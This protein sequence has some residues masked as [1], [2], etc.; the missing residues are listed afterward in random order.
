MRNKIDK[1][2]V[3]IL[4][5][6]RYDTAVAQLGF[7][8]HLVEHQRA[9]LLRVKSEMPSNSRPLYEVLMTGVPTY[10]NGIYSN[11]HAQRSK[12]LSIFELVKKAG[13][14][15]GAAAYYW[16]SE[17]YNQAPYNPLTDRIQHQ[18]QRLIQHGIFYSDDTYPD[19]HLFADA[20]HMVDQYQPD[21]L[22][23]HS[24]NIDDVGHKFTAASR[25]YAAVVNRADSLLSVYIP[26]W[27]HKGYQIVVT[28]DHG[29]DEDGLHGGS[30]A[31]HREV[32]FYVI[33]EKRT[34]LCK[35]NLPQLAAASLFCWLTGIHPS[36]KMSSMEAFVG[37]EK[38]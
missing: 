30:L 11:Y 28:A 17:L 22:V 19:S 4:D 12:E 18:E 16:Y 7:M 36:E 1:L 24:M 10:E 2:I 34:Q 5:G 31:A 15:T 20:N 21:F 26:E 35:E 6:C 23:V 3:V 13:G 38:Q 9:S 29:M 27:L 14:T 33:S 8:N 37:G 25:E 32:P